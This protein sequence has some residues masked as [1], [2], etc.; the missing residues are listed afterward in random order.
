MP[1]SLST[2]A[3]DATANARIGYV[4]GGA[5]DFNACATQNTPEAKALAR[6]IRERFPWARISESP[7]CE[8]MDTPSGPQL[9]IHAVGRAL[10]VMVPTLGGV[11]G[12]Q[13]A[14]WLVANAVQL[15]L[16][17]V[18]WNGSVWQGSI[19]RLGSQPYSGSNPHVD[20]VHVEVLGTVTPT[21]PRL[22]TAAVIAI[23]TSA[24]VG[25]LGVTALVA[26]V[27]RRRRGAAARR[28][29]V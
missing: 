22:S 3:R 2:A 27:R 5:W 4:G 11:E 20:H 10:D 26:V 13:L 18:I 24:A 1:W 28:S 19:A 16:Q 7:R 17:L 25:A 23:G 29:R 12:E 15:G 8:R 9:S 6:I 21:A 14:N